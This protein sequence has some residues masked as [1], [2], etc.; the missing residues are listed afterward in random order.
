MVAKRK[1]AMPS[2]MAAG[3]CL[4]VRSRSSA[5]GERDGQ[6][7]TPMRDFLVPHSTQKISMVSE[8]LVISEGARIGM[9]FAVVTRGVRLSGDL[10]GQPRRNR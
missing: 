8:E 5:M 10:V 3:R 2:P 7:R 4:V 1:R 6:G 9:T